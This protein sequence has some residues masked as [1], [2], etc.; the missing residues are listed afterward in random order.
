MKKKGL[1]AMGLA[2]VMT[3][4][5]CVPVLAA[6]NVWDN[7]SATGLTQ[8]TSV[9]SK[10]NPEYKITIPAT[11]NEQ[12]LSSTGIDIT[13]DGFNLEENGKINIS[14][15]SHEIEMNLGGTTQNE[16]TKKYTVTLKKSD[17]S[18]M[19]AGGIIAVLDENKLKDTI[20]VDL[21]GKSSNLK[22]GEYSG[23]IT[24]SVA[25]EVA[26]DSVS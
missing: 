16:A 3:I 24:F 5:M 23:K 18:N 15:A 8:E 19:T 22:A 2:G 21:S 6:D 12:D 14:V 10:I 25:Y 13:G 11:I 20:K 26:S 4:G 9:N 1:V 7:N 17:G